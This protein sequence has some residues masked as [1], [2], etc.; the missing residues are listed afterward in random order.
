MSNAPSVQSGDLYIVSL[1]DRDLQRR[2]PY[3][4]V[5]R[6]DCAGYAYPLSWAG[7]Y[8]RQDVAER[9]NYLNNGEET[10]AV[11]CALVEALSEPPIPGRI[12]N[13]AGPV[14]RKTPTNLRLLKA[15]RW[16]P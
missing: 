3:V 10:I 9:A 11:P 13:D 4:T 8:T 1:K 6:P 7:K 16:L 15:A 5:W 14:V 2:H 12:D